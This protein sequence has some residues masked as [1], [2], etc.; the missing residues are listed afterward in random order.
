MQND[1]EHHFNPIEALVDDAVGGDTSA[2]FTD[3]LDNLL[4]AVPPYDGAPLAPPPPPLRR[5][6][7]DRTRK[8]EC[9]T[10]A[11]PF[12]RLWPRELAYG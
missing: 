10:T 2:L 9:V 5:S 6:F 4:V 11:T 1:V 12:R 8:G 7:A 3:F